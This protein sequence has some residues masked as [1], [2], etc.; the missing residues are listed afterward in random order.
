MTTRAAP[1]S[2]P[3]PGPAPDPLRPGSSFRGLTI[4]SVL[5]RGAMGTA[6]LASHPILQVPHVIKTF[7]GAADVGIFREAYLGARVSSPNIVPVLDAGIEGSVA[8]AVHQY[9]DGVDLGELL[10]Y[11]QTSQ[12]PLPLPL[13]LRLTRDAARGLHSLHQAGIVHCDVKPANLFLSASGA[14][15]VGDFGIATDVR[16]Q[17]ARRGISGTPLFMAP[18]QWSERPVDRRTDLYSLGATA[19]L[20]ATGSPPFQAPTAMA[21]CLLHVSEPYRPPAASS[22]REAY[23]YAVIERLLRKD[24]AQRYVSGEALARELVRIEDPP[25]QVD[26]LSEDSAQI[27]PLRIT[28]RVADLAAQE[29]DVLVSAAN[30]QMIMDVGVAAALRRAGGES[31]LQE[32]QAQAPRAMGDVVWTGAGR[33]KARHVA[34][35]VAAMGGA[36]CLGR[37]TL[38]TLLGADV[39]KARRVVF[40]ALGT[41]VGGVPLAMAAKL[42]LEAM[43]TF[44]AL[45]PQHVRAVDLALYDEGALKAFREILHS[46]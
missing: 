16:T 35:A 37:S 40:P 17:A 32:A 28:L 39:R 27:G 12:R 36:I 4:H 26:S 24:P 45:Q 10:A 41:G 19:H 43:T 5:G 11:A 22:P 1:A 29:A 9:V 8:F 7:H 21:L 25:L 34:H 14:A 33:L 30:T 18:E 44:A 13:V 2:G 23:F 38:R 6:Y 20:L 46:M 42:M 15:M 31:L 3:A